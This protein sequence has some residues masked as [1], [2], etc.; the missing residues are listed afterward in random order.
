MQQLQMRSVIAATPRS[1][2]RNT[3]TS[4]K[5]SLSSAPSV[6]LSEHHT[7]KSVLSE[8]IDPFIKKCEVLAAEINIVNEDIRSL[9]EKRDQY[10]N[11]AMMLEEEDF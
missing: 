9:S 6:V 3:V 8:N 1:A 11:Q 10:V 2:R 7:K 4:H 5:K